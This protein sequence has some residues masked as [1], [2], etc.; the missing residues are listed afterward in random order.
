MFK[1]YG[2]RSTIELA[3]WEE[4]ESNIVKFKRKQRAEERKY[5]E[6]AE[7]KKLKNRFKRLLGNLKEV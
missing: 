3:H 7:N 2:K 4:C 6:D 1:P 5:K